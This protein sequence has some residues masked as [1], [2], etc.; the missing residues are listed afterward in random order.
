MVKVSADQPLVQVQI[1]FR[2]VVIEDDRTP[3]LG[4]PYFPAAQTSNPTPELPM[5]TYGTTQYYLND[6]LLVEVKGTA[7][8]NVKV[9]VRMV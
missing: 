2:D 8:T 1:G 5:N 9:L 3:K 7:G 4:K 6:D